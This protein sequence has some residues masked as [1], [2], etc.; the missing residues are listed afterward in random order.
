MTRV[1]EAE[2]LLGRGWW[3]GQCW[4]QRACLRPTD[5]STEESLL[6]QIEAMVPVE[7]DSA[8]LASLVCSP[9]GDPLGLSKARE[10]SMGDREL[11]LL[12]LRRQ[13]FGNIMPCLLLCPACSERMDL[14]LKVDDLTVEA[15]AECQLRYEQTME[16]D[17]KSFRVSFRL[18]TGGDVERALHAAPDAEGAAKELALSC[19]ESVTRSGNDPASAVEV[20]PEAWPDSLLQEVS[21]RMEKLDPQGEVRLQLACPACG[22]D[23]DQSLDAGGYLVQEL[24]ARQ[25]AKYQEVHQLALAYHWSEAEILR[26]GPRKRRLYL[27]L[28]NADHE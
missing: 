22:H 13:I 4:E 27:E 26:M 18:P 11:L 7:R 3:T 1:P 25:R 5:D 8:V 2:V 17:D 23:F 10:L 6:H 16:V 21:A 15:G 28:L 19:I 12:L 9:A 14:Q 24:A 20:G